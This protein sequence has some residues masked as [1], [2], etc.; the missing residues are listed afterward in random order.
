MECEN[1]IGRLPTAV[2]LAPLAI[3]KKLLYH[4]VSSTA[5]HCSNF[6]KQGLF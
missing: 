3:Q 5:K 2:T 6:A 4:S 1:A